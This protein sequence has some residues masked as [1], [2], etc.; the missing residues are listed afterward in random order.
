MSGAYT[1]T[2]EIKMED[3]YDVVVAG[4]GPAG[5]AAAICAARLGARVLLIEAMG[6]MGGMGTCGLVNAYDPMADG[7]VML[8]G[9]FMRELI[10]ALYARGFVAP[11]A[12]PDYWRKDYMRWTPFQGEGLK[13]LLDE[14]AVDSGV[15]IR[16]FT[17]VVGADVDS[18]KKR[19]GG[20]IIN[21]VEGFSYIPAKTFIDATG[22]AALAHMSG[23]P[24]RTAGK[25]TPK[26]MPATLA[27]THAGVDFEIVNTRRLPLDDFIRAIETEHE[28]GN[29]T[30]CD[31]GGVNMSQIGR[32]HGYMNGGHIYNMDATSCRELTDGMIFGRKIV[33][34][35]IPLYRKYQPGCENMELVQTGW[36]MG[37]RESRRIFGEYELTLE[38]YMS[39][40][41]FPDQIGVYNKFVDIHPYNTSIE[42]Y[43]RFRYEMENLNLGRGEC[44]GMPYGIL[45]PKGFENLWTAG[46]CVSSDVSVQGVIRVMPPAAMMGQAAGTAA[47]LSIENNRT[48]QTLDTELLIKTLRAKDA[49]LPQDT[50]SKQMTRS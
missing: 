33:Q 43:R 14:F 5:S 45:V 50:L 49:Y 46:R 25:D 11:N 32:Y 9:G 6:C 37:V 44:F 23:A 7:E 2:R 19:L 38:D 17:K 22:D 31:R 3:T 35:L 13:L 12:A 40:K 41:Q 15:E 24:V 1:F 26:I 18:S 4:G 42:E 27:S 47:V 36:L 21:N 34:E 29:L 48:A 10:E 8:V 20:V 28:N 30:Q 39:R 16:Y